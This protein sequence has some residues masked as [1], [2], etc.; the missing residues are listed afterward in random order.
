M[1]NKDILAQSDFSTDADGWTVQ[2]GYPTGISSAP[3]W[4]AASP[5]FSGGV[6][7]H[8]P[9]VA[10]P[11]GEVFF[12]APAKFLGDLSACYGENFTF[13]L[14]LELDQEPSPDDFYTGTQDI[15]IEGSGD[16]L[17]LKAPVVDPFNPAALGDAQAIAVK[18]DETTPCILQSTGKAPTAA[19]FRNVLGNVTAILVRIDYYPSIPN[20]TTFMGA[21]TLYELTLN[22]VLQALYDRLDA[23]RKASPTGAITLDSDTLGPEGAGILEVLPAA[24]GTAPATF[25]G[26]GLSLATDPTAQ[27]VSLGGTGEDS[28]VSLSQPSLTAIFTVAAKSSDILMQ[29]IIGAED[30]W[31]L[32]QSFPL[33]TKTYFSHITYLQDGTTPP[34]LILSSTSD[35]GQGYAKGLN[36]RGDLATTQWPLNALSQLISGVGER[37]S[38]LGPATSI[39]TD[40]ESVESVTIATSLPDF[41]L[42]ETILPALEFKNNRLA[43][44]ATSSMTPVQDNLVEYQAID[45]CAESHVIVNGV[46]L[47]LAV[48]LPVPGSNWGVGLVPGSTVPIGQLTDFLAGF[49][50][51]SLASALPGAIAALNVF[52]LKVLLLRLNDDRTDFSSFNLALGTI[53][54]D[55]SGSVWKIIDGVIELHDLNFNLNVI[56][57][58]AGDSRTSGFIQG[59]VNLGTSLQVGA[60]VTLPI[61]QGTWTFSARTTQP[62]NALDAIGG[63]FGSNNLSQSLPAG[64]GSLA[65]YN[66]QDLSFTYDPAAQ[67]LSQVHLAISTAEAWHIVADQLVVE[68]LYLDLTVDDPRGNGITPYGSVGGALTIGTL[69]IAAEASRADATAPWLL[70]VAAEAVALPSLADLTTLLA[71]QSVADA[72]PDTLATNSFTLFGVSVSANLST[73]KVEKIT[74]GLNTNDEWPIINDILV[75][76]GA[77]TFFAFDWTGAGGTLSI[78]GYIAGT[79]TFIDANFILE[80]AKRSDGWDLSAQLDSATPFTLQKVVTK[81]GGSNLWNEVA[82]LGVPDVSI[83]R[84][85]LTYATDTGDYAL[86]GTVDF[87]NPD[88]NK[89]WTIDI[90]IT[91][92]TIRSLGAGITAV[93]G[94]DGSAEDKKIY[95]TGAFDIGSVK[96]E[97]EYDTSK[98]VEVDCTLVE[99]DKSVSAEAI[100]KSLLGDTIV[101]NISYTGEFTPLNEILFSGVHAQLIV[102]TGN[103]KSSFR[104]Y[105]KIIIESVQVDALLAIQYSS[106]GWGFVVAIKVDSNWSLSGFTDT[107][108]IFN[109]DKQTW[110]VSVSSFTV[111]EFAY[112]ESFNVPNYKGAFKYLDFYASFSTGDTAP[113]VGGVDKLLP[114]KQLPP[115]LTVMGVVADTLADSWLKCMLYADPDGVPIF[116]W[117]NMRLSSIA[118]V[119]TGEPAVA[120]ESVFLYKGIYNT[121]PNTGEK[122]YFTFQ[123]SAG[124]TESYAFIIASGKDG[125]PIFTWHDP[126]GLDGFTLQLDWVKLGLVFAELGIEGGFEGQVTFT[127]PPNGEAVPTLLRNTA[128]HPAHVAAVRAKLTRRRTARDRALALA[129]KETNYTPIPGVPTDLAA[130]CKEQEPPV[131]DPAY[132]RPYD[133]DSLLVKMLAVIAVTVET[134]GI[135]IPQE[136]GA[137]I[138]NVTIPYLLKQ[139]VHIDVPDIIQ[140]IRL[141]DVCFYISIGESPEVFEFYL[142]G[143]IEVFHWHGEIE[144]LF[145]LPHIKFVAN[146]DPIVIGLSADDPLIVVAKSNDDL[147]HGPDIHVDSEPPAGQPMIKGDIYCS[148]LKVFNFEWHIDVAEGPPPLIMFT[149]TQTIGHMVDYELTFTYKD[150]LYIHATGGFTLNLTDQQGADAITGFEVSKDNQSYRIANTIDLTKISAGVFLSATTDFTLDANPASTPKF[151]LVFT[152]DFAVKLGQKC[153]ITCHL[154][155]DTDVQQDTLEQLPVTIISQL[156]NNS[157]QVFGALVETA[158]CFAHFLK[159]GL[160]IL[161]DAADAAKTLAGFFAVSIETFVYRLNYLGNRLDDISNW[162]WD[163]FDS[164]DSETNTKVLRDYTG[165]Q[166][167]SDDVAKAVKQTQDTYQPQQ[168]YT[169]EDLM[170]DQANAGYNSTQAISALKAAFDQYQPGDMAAA[171]GRLAADP[172][173]TAYRYTDVAIALK[174]N[175]SGQTATAAAMH[176]LLTQVYTGASSLTPQ[177]MANALAAAGYPVGDVAKVLHDNYLADVPTAAAMATFL[178]TAYQN[179]SPALTGDSLAGALAPFYEAPPVAKVIFD[180]FSSTYQDQPAAMATTLTTAYTAA[181]KPVDAPTMTAALAGCG[182]PIAKTAPVIHQ[183]YS[184]DTATALAMAALLYPAYNHPPVGDMTA[185][186]VACGYDAT[187]IG[188]ALQQYYGTDVSTPAQMAALF[189]SNGVPLPQAAKA[190][191]SLFNSGSIPNAEAM[192]TILNGAYTNPLPTCP[193]MA[194]ALSIAPYTP[195]ESA[196]A[197][198]KTYPEDTATA[199]EMAGIL[200]TA[201]GAGTIEAAVMAQALAASPFSATDTAGVLVTDYHGDSD[202]VNKL[203]GLLKGAPYTAT[204]TTTALR[205][206]YAQETEHAN[207]TAPILATAGYSI[208]DVAPVLKSVYPSEVADAATMYSVLAAA[209]TS[210]QPT[211]PDMAAALAASPFTAPEVAPVLK[212]HYADAT[213]TAEEMYALLCGAYTDPAPTAPVMAEALAASYGVTEVAPLLRSHYSADADTAEKMATLL[214]SAYNALALPDCLSGLAA[215]AFSAYDSAAAMP[216]HY[217]PLPEAATFATALDTAYTGPAALGGAQIGVGL[218]AASYDAT[219]QSVGIHTVKPDTP[220]GLMAAY[221]LALADSDLSTGLT[222]SDTQLQNGED[223]NTAAV[224]VAQAVSTISGEILCIALNSVYA[225]PNQTVAALAQA[226]AG[227]FANAESQAASL[228]TGLLL[229][230]PAATPAALLNTLT[231]G[232]TAAGK[233]LDPAAAG[234]A[235]AA[236]FAAIG[237]PLPQ[238]GLISLMLAKYGQQVTPAQ[239]VTLLINAYGES[240]TVQS[241]VEALADGYNQAQQLINAPVTA[242]AVKQGFQLTA[243]DTATTLEVLG[244]A[245]SLTR[246]PNDVAA[247]GAAMNAATF[248]LNDVSAAMKTYYGANWTVEAYQELSEVYSQALFQSAIQEVLAGTPVQDTGIKLKTQYPET[249]APLM[250][251]VLSSA[252]TLTATAV[253]VVPVAEAMKAAN[254]TLVFTAAAMKTQYQ[255]DWTVEDYQEVSRIFAQP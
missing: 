67:K 28:A 111:P 64:L 129:M 9:P 85:G 143:V 245:F 15:I 150:L 178:V 160:F 164:H 211:A 124:V 98:G 191:K 237:A 200:T 54:T 62:I 212:A 227:A 20:W 126:L 208:I 31:D 193:D 68:S 228:A 27:T 117:D 218:M 194:A 1:S 7:F 74:F 72:L 214:T 95:V 229:V 113:A 123:L 154:N 181:A 13:E 195:V 33:L 201:Y 83:T 168:P 141:P 241:V 125:S 26:D 86:D 46:E 2:T 55:A 147:T 202:T 6:I 19:Q 213:T 216:A 204:D 177:Q 235:V 104:L 232:F 220:A 223:L 45:L 22:P 163:I 114:S 49:A 137:H 89:P 39:H 94:K 30:E 215:A 165:G 25:M 182:Y 121:D 199:T 99:D 139:F 196:P 135:P 161:L 221:L 96:F 48:Y 238:S 118:F 134:E 16:A 71:G 43:L 203:A 108:D 207:Q 252:Y 109:F 101:D 172:S 73:P 145:Q 21:P 91:S 4:E 77:E 53:P 155:F 81:F 12:S 75:V 61:G 246:V 60:S 18:L 156:G 80:A 180:D 222:A 184:T 34:A 100:A 149:Y 47:P 133:Q 247:L 23:A 230:S 159:E 183:D 115:S 167:S 10:R 250:V 102:G 127:N 84:G 166:Y 66:L 197:L 226:C 11:D 36:V 78:T 144:A 187:E 171:A 44:Y 41:S 119:I 5:G 52:E 169:A 242:D 236:A 255:P 170:K 59:S 185:A 50:G 79:I 244:N 190:L 225:P 35:S 51:V 234:S 192:I 205:Q 217:T 32:D 106:A 174:A 112:P 175:Y 116:G 56:K 140:P 189:A 162:L 87:T 148:F 24:F 14:V 231:G 3:F 152:S 219:G 254:Y 69:H 186:L 132:E 243:K 65:S 88:D 63:L 253:G 138:V 76:T 198:K 38:T 136:I 176:T 8:S 151:Q 209:F 158:E 110:M 120:L 173:L 224:K 131:H 90:G 153:N 142:H 240:A 122:T 146:M 251:H 17:E 188:Q 92:I 206:Y 130:F 179:I 37:L 93:R 233:S 97:A 58:K 42:P 103:N 29:M 105:G 248:G 40:Q 107:L 239:L 82:A 70:L 210:P 128:P 249:S 157:G 57:T